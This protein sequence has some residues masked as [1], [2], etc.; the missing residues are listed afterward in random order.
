MTRATL[1]LRSH[2]M[3]RNASTARGGGTAWV[4]VV[5]SHGS[6]R[7]C[8][9]RRERQGDR[10]GRKRRL[11]GGPPP[12]SRRRAA[13][14]SSSAI[15]RPSPVPPVPFCREV[16]IEDPVPQVPID[17]GPLVGERQHRALGARD[18]EVDAGAA[19]ACG[20]DRVLAE[21]GEDAPH[22]PAVEGDRAR[23]GSPPRPRRRP[24]R[25][26]ACSFARTRPRTRPAP[27]L[28]PDLGQLR[29]PG[30]LV[31]EPLQRPDPRARSRPPRRAASRTRGPPPRTPSQRASSCWN[32]SFIGVSGFLISC[33]S[34]RATSCQP[35]I[36]SR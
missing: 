19:G 29:E 26:S 7:A 24:S 15:A 33:A 35:E 4:W 34:R 12:G 6:R 21:V 10:E 20:V 11:Q 36:F 23:R 8:R 31:H 28:W 3:A 27:R 5:M 9:L 25:R 16:R 2:A 18:A 22:E 1:P 32:A 17:A 30:E 13:A 14:R